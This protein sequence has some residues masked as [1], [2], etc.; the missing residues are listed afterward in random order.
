MT[1]RY[2]EGQ[3]A[4]KFW[5]LVDKT[6]DPSGCWLWTGKKQYQGYG[7]VHWKGKKSITHRVAYFITGHT[8]PEG[9]VLAHSEHCVGKR[10]CCN[11]AHLTPKTTAEN[12]ADKWRDGTAQIGEKCYQAILTE[13]QVLEIRERSNEIQMDL[14]KEFGIKQPTVSAIICRRIWKHI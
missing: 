1:P 4:Q 12:V 6:S 14:A 11:P 2:T 5:E 3:F 7:T 9:L 8:I 10:H 13:A